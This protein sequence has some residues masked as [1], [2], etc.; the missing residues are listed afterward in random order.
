M[1][2]HPKLREFVDDKVKIFVS[3]DVVVTNGRAH[4]AIAGCEAIFSLGV[5]ESAGEF[6]G[7]YLKIDFD[8][9]YDTALVKRVTEKFGVGAVA[10]LHVEGDFH[11]ED[12]S[13]CSVIEAFRIHFYSDK[14]DIV[15]KIENN[16]LFLSRWDGTFNNAPNTLLVDTYHPPLTREDIDQ[17]ITDELNVFNDN[18]GVL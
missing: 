14:P 12:E 13:S 7:N 1:D 9:D 6:V 2:L 8:A 4:M 16:R 15:F 17:F 10:T 18:W 5:A 11:D 3:P